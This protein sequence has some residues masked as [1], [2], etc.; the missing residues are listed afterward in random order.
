MTKG[1]P[2]KTQNREP[3]DALAAKQPKAMQPAVNMIAQTLGWKKIHIQNGMNGPTISWFLKLFPTNNN[4]KNTKCSLGHRNLV[5]S[6]KETHDMLP[7]HSVLPV[8]GLDRPQGDLRGEKLLHKK[9]AKAHRGSGWTKSC[10]LTYHTPCHDGPPHPAISS[11]NKH[12]KHWVHCVQP[13]NTI[14]ATLL[15]CTE[16]EK[17]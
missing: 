3:R 14:P 17:K 8:R 16:F 2:W 15:A 6:N 7:P 5:E 12:V 11:K 13:C 4:K 9:L 10:T 1:R